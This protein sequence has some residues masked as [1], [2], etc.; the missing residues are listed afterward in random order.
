MWLAGRYLRVDSAVE[1]ICTSIAQRAGHDTARGDEDRQ[2]GHKGDDSSQQPTS[3]P[4]LV[5]MYQSILPAASIV[6]LRA[7]RSMLSSG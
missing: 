2:R 6:G 1:A 5:K 3:M 7:F 4:S